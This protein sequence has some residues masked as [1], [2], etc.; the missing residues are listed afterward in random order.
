MIPIKDIV[1]NPHVIHKRYTSFWYF[2]LQSYEGGVDYTNSMLLQAST[3]P[4]MLDSLWNYFVNGVQ[5]N[6]QTIVGNLFKH[7]KERV[8]DYNRRINMSYYYN[9]CAPIIE[10]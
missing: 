3:N 6:T 10:V 7:P 1:E 9:F 5:Q 8:E 4:G 2:L